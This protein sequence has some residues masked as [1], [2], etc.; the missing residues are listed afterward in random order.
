MVIV[1][2]AVLPAVSEPG[3]RAL[4]LSVYSGISGGRLDDPL[5]PQPDRFNNKAPSAR[6]APE[7][8]QKNPLMFASAPQP[9]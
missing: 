7:I 8:G 1:E 5:L 2:V 4:A 9:R 6:T 3:F